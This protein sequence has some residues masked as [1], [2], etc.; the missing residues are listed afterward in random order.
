M[1]WEGADGN[2]AFV[3]TMIGKQDLM[4]CSLIQKLRKTVVFCGY[5]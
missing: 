2:V 1:G 4:A 3:C 5:P